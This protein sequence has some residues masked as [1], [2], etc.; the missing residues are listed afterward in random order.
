MSKHTYHVDWDDI[1]DRSGISGVPIK[2]VNGAHLQI[3]RI[4]LA[5][6]YQNP[7]H[8]HPSEQTGIVLAG[9]IE[10]DIEGTVI[11][12]HVGDS[13]IIPAGKLHSVRVISAEPALLFEV[14]SPPRA[15][16]KD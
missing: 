8:R 15:E 14:F 12:R 16:Y 6:G 1:P 7:P 4:P 9:A 2:L 5:P 11:T 3:A 10:Y 13:Y